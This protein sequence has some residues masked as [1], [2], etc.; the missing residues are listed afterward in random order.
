MSYFTKTSDLSLNPIARVQI[1]DRL[2]GAAFAGLRVVIATALFSL[3][4]VRAL[5]GAPATNHFTFLAHAFL[6]GTFS[7]GALP[8]SYADTIQ[9][10]SQVFLPMGPAPAMLL[11]PFVSISGVAFDELWLS[12]G[13][14][15]LNAWLLNLI[16]RQIGILDPNKR[17]WLLALFLIGTIYFAAM[18][19]GR[20]W[21]LSHISTTMFL[22]LAIYLWLRGRAPGLVG[23]LLGLSFLTRSSTL[24]ALPFFLMLA[25]HRS[26]GGRTVRDALAI[27]LGLAAPVIFFF[28]Y[29]YARFGHI[30]E[31]GYAYALP[32]APILREALRYGLVSPVHIP[33]NIY[34]LL[35]SA[36]E[37]IPG[38]GAPVLQFPWI[39]PS[40]WGMGL[41]WT[42]PAFVY[43]FFANYRQR[44][45]QAAAVAVFAILP[46][47][48][49]YYGVGYS[50][51]G[52]RY[53]I[54]FFPFLFILTALGLHARWSWAAKFLIVTSIV[55]NIWGA[56]CAMFGLFAEPG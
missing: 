17:R 32:G 14:T 22:L 35:F 54:D 19:L 49:M 52:Y 12:L 13:L 8:D 29:N 36:P 38:L 9:V 25:A 45:A 18:V 56:W 39:L 42:T 28:V 44:L 48:L 27:A 40:R 24:L 10:G 4:G 1:R 3:L 47:L 11:M 33:K 7:V 2:A 16:L 37:P 41:F 23:L 6:R 46:L 53:G 43:A 20:S 15:G 26:S 30:L 31:T 51:F 21:F 34:M 5:A 55:V 50:Q